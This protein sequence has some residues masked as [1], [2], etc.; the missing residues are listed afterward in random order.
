MIIE[1]T[2][3]RNTIL[4][5]LVS[6]EVEGSPVRRSALSRV[7]GLV[8][9]RGLLQLKALFM[10]EGS[11]HSGR[12]WRGEGCSS[13]RGVADNKVNVVKILKLFSGLDS[14]AHPEP[15]FLSDGLTT[16][17]A[18]CLLGSD[19]MVMDQLLELFLG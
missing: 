6:V 1:E 9:G 14:R 8:C 2:D 13:F 12:L 11:S 3:R 16:M 19:L 4:E 10:A 15:C 7:Q 17:W 18:M 5:A